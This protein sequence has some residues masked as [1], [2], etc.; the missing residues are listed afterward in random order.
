MLVRAREAVLETHSYSLVTALCSAQGNLLEA[1]S[2]CGDRV[3]ETELTISRL[4][5][6]PQTK[7]S[8]EKM[9][10]KNVH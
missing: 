8:R 5:R 3:W 4:S 10:F 2:Q 1:M 6:F 9:Q 7:Q